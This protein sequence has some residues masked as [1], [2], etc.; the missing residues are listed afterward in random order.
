MAI[1]SSLKI[2]SAIFRASLRILFVIMMV[3]MSTTICLANTAP[4]PQP[5]A[6]IVFLNP[7]EPVDRGKGLF[8]PLTARLMAVAAETFGMELEVLYAERD[9]LLMLRQAES[10]SQRRDLP[11]YVVMVNEK[12]TAPKMLQMFEGTSTKV[13]LIHNDMTLEQRQEFG[14][15]REQMSH[16]IGT[17]T[18]DEERGTYRMMEELY[19]QLGTSEPSVIGIT[20]ERGTPVSLERAQGVSDYITQSG[21]GQQVQ[22]AFGNWGAADAESKADILL[23]RYPQANIIWAANYSMA[24]GALRAVKASGAP[25]LVGSTAVAPYSM[26]NIAMEDMA[27][28][29]G[30]HFFIGAWAMVLLYDYHNGMDFAAHGGARQR[31][32]YLSVI[33]AEN[34][35]RYYEIVYEQTDSLDFS[36][37]SKHLNLSAGSYDFS[38]TP[39][40]SNK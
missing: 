17:A 9:H 33:N 4:E 22:L 27:V 15:E 37:F 35:P 18:T 5:A 36:V 13:L 1:M 39:L 16:W 32:D 40:M 6:R 28:S 23:A 38:L 26:A 24:L 31:L 3:T 29:L 25:V 34:A 20:G 8:W 7:G 21:R 11:D 10:L 2:K 19:R 12:Q 30:S 14:N